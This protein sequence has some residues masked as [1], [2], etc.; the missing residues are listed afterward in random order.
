MV[1]LWESCDNNMSPSPESLAPF[2]LRLLLNDIRFWLLIFFVIRLFG[3]TDPPIEV[4]H[5]WRQATVT[6]AARNFFEVSNN[7]AYPR[8]DIL[9]EKAGVG[10]TGITGM[11]FPIFNYLI[12]LASE[13]FGYQHWYGRLINLITSTV[14]LWF[15]YQ[16]ILIYFN[17]KIAFNATI[18]L[19]VSVWFQFS[20]KIMPDTFAMSMVLGSLYYGSLFLENKNE[21][22][23]KRKRRSDSVTLLSFLFFM[24]LGVLA[25]LPSGYLYV[26]FVLLYFKE[27]IL[28]KRKIIF[29][30]VTSL[31][32]IPIVAWYFFWV[33]HLVETYGSSFFMGNSISQ[34][35]NEII[36]RFPTTLYRFYETALKVTGFVAFIFGVLYAAF[37]KDKVIL[38]I[39]IASFLSFC[40]IILKAGFIFPLHSYYIIPFVPV[41][42]LLA[43]Y[44]LSKIKYPKFVLFALVAISVEGIAKQHL[45]L[46]LSE[47]ERSLVLLESDLDKVSKPTDLILI[48]SG[49]YPT[50]LYFSHRKGWVN[51]NEKINNEGYINDLGSRGLKYI[52][53]LKR[54]FGSE[55]K[56]NQYKIVLN[57]D[58]YSIYRVD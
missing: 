16:L 42:S 27:S 58:D 28:L 52:V 51:S 21:Y 50:P 53:I 46:F 22:L 15:F 36:E 24:V 34:G 39:L 12:Y 17:R 55:I 3:I 4:E 43:G 49:L 40:I 11:E 19:A 20:R 25:K 13:L 45:D 9:G 29:A 18:I 57:N 10:E 1:I 37:N 41:M 35:L 14:G 32:L 38:L 31:G 5:N 56:L 54:I 30:I 7:I 26:L 48:N 44:G 47:K 2:R 8:I 6:M 23:E 33:P